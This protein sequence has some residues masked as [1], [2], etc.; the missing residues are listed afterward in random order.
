MHYRQTCRRINDDWVLI[1]TFL[2][3][4]T[5]D[6]DTLEFIKNISYPVAI[7]ATNIMAAEDNLRNEEE[8][9][10]LLALSN[11]IATIKKQEDLAVM[12]N[13]L[14]KHM[15]AINEFG[16]A[17]VHE[18]GQT[19]GS[20]HMEMG[21]D[22]KELEQFNKITS[23]KYDVTDYVFREIMQSEEPVLLNV[24]ELLTQTWNSAYVHFWKRAGIR[25]VLSVPLRDG[26]KT[27]GFVNFHV[28]GNQ[29][30]LKKTSLLKSVC[31]QLLIS[32]FQYTGE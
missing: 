12:A 20:F 13:R 27:V 4:H 8:K 11:E 19:Y 29:T 10:R 14:V 30:I 31:T 28:D 16:I 23:D 3:S 5:C 25:D 2:P 22:I 32:Y 15:L 18:N 24:D 1:F 9:S 21:K 6:Q 26:N 7:A 17:Y